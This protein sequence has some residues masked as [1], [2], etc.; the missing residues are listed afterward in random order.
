MEI[1]LHKTRKS[2]A[3]FLI[4]FFIVWAVLYFNSSFKILKI[5][6]KYYGFAIHASASELRA[7]HS[8]YNQD[9]QDYYQI[10][11]MCDTFLPPPEPLQIVLPPQPQR[12]FEFLREKGRYILY[13]RNYG[14]NDSPQ[15]Y[16]LVYGV[17]NFKKPEGYEMVRSF[18]PDKYLLKRKNVF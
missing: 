10:L 7:Y 14:D 9:F 2:Q 8:I 11:Q 15:N 12:R 16:I 18:G 3:S 1:N 17:Q 6:W 5:F 4:A 13:P